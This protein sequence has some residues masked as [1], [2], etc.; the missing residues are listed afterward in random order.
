MRTILAL[1]LSLVSCCAQTD[2]GILESG[3]SLRI[4]L[5]GYWRLEEA[6]GT[7]Y[8]RSPSGFT[9]TANNSPGQAVGKVGN[10]ATFASASAQSLS[11]A[12]SNS[13]SFL[14]ANPFSCHAWVKLTNNTATQIILG[15]EQLST[16]RGWNFGA[17][18]GKLYFGLDCASSVGMSI[19]GTTIITNAAWHSVLLT[20]N[21]NSNTN[22]MNLYCDGALETLSARSKSGTITDIDNTGFFTIG[23]LT[24]YTTIYGNGMIDEVG[25][26]NRVLTASEI[27]QLYTSGN[28][29]TH[30][31]AH[32]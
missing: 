15:K 25:V 31:F 13:L 7:R 18:A 30:P 22:G 4:G 19:Q 23:N 6:S 16:S 5:K 20:Y 11:A 26:W 17:V 32:K 28:G 21:G 3:S 29:I 2:P 1:L 12:S 24:G 8:D 27:V 9:L 10:C 14:L